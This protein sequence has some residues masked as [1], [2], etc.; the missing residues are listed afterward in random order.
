MIENPSKGWYIRM[1]GIEKILDK[2]QAESQA[3]ADAILSNARA[4]AEAITARYA[5]QVEQEKT[6]AEEKGR[7]AAAERQDRLIRAAEMESKKTILGAKQAVLDRAFAR[8]RE[9]L[10]DMPRD[11]YAALLAALAAGSA[12]T[13]SEALVFSAKDRAALGEQVTA[14]ANRLRAQAGKPA[15][16]TLSE[17]TAEI[18]GGLLLRDQSS[19]VNCT[20][21]TLLR[22]SR[23]ELAGQ[24]AAILFD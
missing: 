21:E 11:Q 10:L 9:I 5:K 6:A 7:K 18:D 19:E 14:E 8:A 2:L 22:L 16:L 23:E 12:G 13:G 1:N 20:F 24:A 4:E 15:S 3:E 17:E